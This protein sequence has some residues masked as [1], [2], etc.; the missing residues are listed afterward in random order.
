MGEKRKRLAM[1][2]LDK[3]RGIAVKEEEEENDEEGSGKECEKEGEYHDCTCQ[4][5]KP[6]LSSPHV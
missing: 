5:D 6:F 1:A 3:V 4:V 2:Q